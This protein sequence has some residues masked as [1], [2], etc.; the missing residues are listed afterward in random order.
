MAGFPVIARRRSAADAVPGRELPEHVR[1][2]LPAGFDAVGE[3][4]V[5]GADPSAACTEI[6]RAFARDGASLGEALSG[7]RGTYHRVT[8]HEPEFSVTEALAV[9]WS[10][11]TLEFVHQLSCEDPLTGLTSLAHVRTRLDEIYR[12]AE[13]DGVDMRTAH[14]LVVVEASAP[15]Q[16]HFGRAL[17][18]A[19]VAEAMRMVFAS[20]ETVGRLSGGRAVAVVRRSPDLGAAVAVLREYLDDLHLPATDVRLWIEGLPRTPDSAMKLLDELA[21]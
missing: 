13:N 21:R 16:D 11:T 9:S 18:L 17:V 5:Q 19:Q 10:E 3:A 1:H 8:G 6:G 7:L 20:G 12:E 2:Q 4:L 15:A 14:A